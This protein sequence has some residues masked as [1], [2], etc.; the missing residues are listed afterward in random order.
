MTPLKDSGAMKHNTSVA[1][2]HTR[3]LHIAQETQI[4]ASLLY[5]LTIDS[6]TFHIPQGMHHTLSFVASCD[7]LLVLF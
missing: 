5:H 2:K 3:K 6:F 1:A 7:L 4:R